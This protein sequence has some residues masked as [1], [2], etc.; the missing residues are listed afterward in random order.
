MKN[1]NQITSE[2][3]NQ[4]IQCC[5]VWYEQVEHIIDF[6]KNHDLE[7]IGFHFGMIYVNDYLNLEIVQMIEEMKCTTVLKCF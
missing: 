2:H 4:I 6:R 7:Y 5:C 3:I 1:S